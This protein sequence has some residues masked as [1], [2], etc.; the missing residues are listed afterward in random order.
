[1]KESNSMLEAM[2]SLNLQL[3]TVAGQLSHDQSIKATEHDNKEKYN[4]QPM[5]RYINSTQEEVA[6]G[7]AQIAVLQTIIKKIGADKQSLLNRLAVDT[8]RD[9]Q[10]GATVQ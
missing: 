10:A 6:K 9:K 1:M 2:N 5:E 3:K 4:R 8:P 7:K